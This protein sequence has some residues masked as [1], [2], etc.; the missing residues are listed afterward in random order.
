MVWGK[1]PVAEPRC[2][3]IPGVSFPFEGCIS[4]DGGVDLVN[5]PRRSAIAEVFKRAAVLGRRVYGFSTQEVTT[6]LVEKMRVPESFDRL[7]VEGD[8]KWTVIPC[9]Y[10]P[11][12]RAREYQCPTVDADELNRRWQGYI[13]DPDAD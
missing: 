11:P 3:T 6:A 8:G 4:C 2:G 5:D 1:L 10:V 7:C 13:Q 9:D 12:V